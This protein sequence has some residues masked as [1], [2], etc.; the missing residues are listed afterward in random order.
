MLISFTLNNPGGQNLNLFSSSFFIHR[1]DRFMILPPREVS[2]VEEEVRPR[3][4]SLRQQP[5]RRFSTYIPST[6]DMCHQQPSTSSVVQPQQQ[7]PPISLRLKRISDPIADTEKMPPPKISKIM[8]KKASPVASTAS[9][10][11]VATPAVTTATTLTMPKPMPMP[12]PIEKVDLNALGL[13]YLCFHCEHQTDNFDAIHAHWL[14]VH[15][16]GEDPTTKRFCYRL[17]KQVRC[18]YC[19]SNCSSS[20]NSSI[21]SYQT[22]RKHMASQ[23]KN[24][25]YAYV[26]HNPTKTANEPMECGQCAKIMPTIAD[27]QMH[28][29]AKHKN[30]QKPTTSSIDPLPIINDA[31]LNALLEQG[32]Q[33]TFKC[34]YCSCFYSCRYDYDQHHR[35]DHRLIPQKY[36]LNGKYVIKYGCFVCPQIKTD[37]AAAIEH[38]RAHFPIGYQCQ[39]CP[40]QFKFLSAIVPHHA[41]AHDA[42]LP[43]R[44]KLICTQDHFIACTQLILTFSNGLTLQWGD[45]M[46]TKF[47]GENRLRKWVGSLI[48]QQNQQQLKAYN[49]VI[50]SKD[51]TGNGSGAGGSSGAPGMNAG[52]IGHRRQTHL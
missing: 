2:T 5:K 48:E 49:E 14:K 18:V 41:T 40:T 11:T 6:S 16:K 51:F 44:F 26:K 29:D 17:T 15:K 25:P 43:V 3:P 10:T 22:I 42:N 38:I 36:E 7:Q 37:E 46:N 34:A 23:H 31:T 47:G 52:K 24:C 19:L 21:F 39:Y 9:T 28:F 45:V 32:D 1:S 4:A 33:G 30:L 12:N 8:V 50:K 27:L 20:N 13:I 35:E